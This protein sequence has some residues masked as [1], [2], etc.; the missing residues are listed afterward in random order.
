MS[1]QSYA[2]HIRFVPG[3]HIVLGLLLI[4]GTIASIVNTWLKFSY[5]LGE[6]NPLLITVL[7]ICGLLLFWYTRQ[8][9]IKAQDRV[10]RAEENLRYFILTGEPLDSRVTMA[11]VI[12]LRFA[13]DD[14]L[15]ALVDRAVKEALPPKEIKMAVK[16]WRA[17]NHR[18]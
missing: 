3:F 8:F 7:F 9:P 10:I 6:F 2:K 12:A 5:H 16:Q 15:V 4:L 1:E 13:S 11:Q 18:M 14:E 17:D